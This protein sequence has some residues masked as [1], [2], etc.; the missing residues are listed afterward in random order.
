[1][2]L[3]RLRVVQLVAAG[4]LAV[5]VG[6][7][8]VSS[9]AGA[10]LRATGSS[11]NT[12][13]SGSQNT[14]TFQ[15][16]AQSNALDV[17]VNDP[18]A[19]LASDLA[20]EAGPWGASAAINSLGEAM[21]DAGAPYSPSVADLPG[22]VNGIG[23]GNLPPLPPIPGYV[24][25]SYP[26]TPNNTQTQG[27]YQI[28]STASQTSAKGSVS[29]GVQ[30]A[31]SPN[32]TMFATAQTTAN[33]DGSVSVSA[34]AGI[35]ALDFGQLFDIGN[36][37]S[38][39]SMTQQ[40]NQQ[41]KVTSQTNL[42]TVTLVGSATGLSTLGLSA[43][44][45]GVP[46]NINGAVLSA[47]DTLLKPA[48]VTLTY[49]PETFTYTDG[50]SNT[51]SSPDTSKTLESIDSGALQITVAQNVPSQGPTS[52]TMTLGRVY[53]STTNTPGLNPTGNTGTLT[54]TGTTGTGTTGSI[55]F[56]PSGNSGA[57]GVTVPAVSTGGSTPPPASTTPTGQSLGETPAYAIELGPPIESL[58]LV[59]VLAALALLLGSQAVRYLAVR[60]SL[61]DRS[62]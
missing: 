12:G 28:S 44:G 6:G 11:G 20:L 43:L 51:G 42:G 39:M 14:N 41:P 9:G 38:T 47:L 29:L 62:S 25:A 1:M 50:S 58:Y 54:N 23:A 13:N 46:I 2:G 3:R 55:A 5:G 21:S 31:G 57:L 17:L 7:L 56:T 40:A 19:P 24:S 45:V 26:S 34:S 32:P 36:V 16:S 33:N 53:I 27:G 60:L 48:G 22:T 52:V 61:S 18:S 37:S 30:P 49:L 35:D 15:L 10:Q 8:L 4:A 59:L